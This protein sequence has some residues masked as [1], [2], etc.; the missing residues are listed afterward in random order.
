VLPGPLGADRN[1]PG[2]E[3]TLLHPEMKKKPNKKF[4]LVTSKLFGV[5]S[6]FIKTQLNFAWKMQGGRMSL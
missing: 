1:L 3:K 2:P 4:T 5:S 6:I